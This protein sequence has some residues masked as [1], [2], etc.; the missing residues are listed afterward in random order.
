[1]K[2]NKLFLIAVFFV[3]VF[4]SACGVI[5]PSSIKGSGDIITESRDVSG[6]DKVTLAGFGDVTIEIGDQESLTVTTDDNIMSYV[7]TEVK[8]NTLVLSLDDPGWNSGFN[9]TDGIKYELVVTE[10]SRV[11]V[12]GAGRVEVND[13]ETEKLRVDLSG[14]GS[15]EINSLTA[16]EFVVNQSG[17]GTIFASGQVKGQELTSSGVGSYHATELESETAIVEFSGAGSA[18]LWVTELLDISISGV[19]NVIYYGSPRIIQNVSGV[20]NLIS[21]EK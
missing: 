21:A 12:S 1:M 16:D 10:L 3:M 15:F 13:L 20:G 11:N 9:P 7:E 19:G 2:T 14:A 4:T 6:F 18:S 8:N 5:I 17:A